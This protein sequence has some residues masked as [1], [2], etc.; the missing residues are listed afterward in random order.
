MTSV[1]PPPATGAPEEP[2]DVA[3]ATRA[4]AFAE[5]R[6]FLSS[7]ATAIGR[8]T[9][10]R[11]EIRSFEEAEHLAT[12]LAMQYPDT[13]RAAFGIWELL[14]N[15][16]EHGNL[17]IG[18]GEKAELLR[19]GR[20]EEE[21]RRRMADPVLAARLVTVSFSRRRTS[22]RLTIV[23]EGAGFDPTPFLQ[24]ATAGEMQPNGRG[25]R[26]AAQFSFDDLTYAGR[27]NQAIATTKLPPP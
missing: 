20:Y 8:L 3:A 15:A 14:A 11:F 6:A 23:D 21:I 27:G 18:C 25:I 2:D 22:L 9:S 19:Q 1:P 13:D 12:M 4:R 5:I 7:H 24:P 10:A 16:I 17:G 26:L